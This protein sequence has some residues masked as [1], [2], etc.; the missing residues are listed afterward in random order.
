MVRGR[1]QSAKVVTF[2][3]T[4]VVIQNQKR[5]NVAQRLRQRWCVVMKLPETG[6]HVA[7]PQRSA[8]D[9]Y[10]KTKKQTSLSADRAIYKTSYTVPRYALLYGV[11]VQEYCKT[12]E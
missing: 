7:M 9:E 12:G 8:G 11:E 2:G 10:T 5:E 4:E 1:I 3:T 6:V